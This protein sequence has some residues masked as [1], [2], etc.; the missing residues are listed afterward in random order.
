MWQLIFM[1]SLEAFL[2]DKTEGA[3]KDGYCEDNK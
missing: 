3:F 2:C 1:T